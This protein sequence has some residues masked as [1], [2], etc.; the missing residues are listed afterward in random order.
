MRG[1]TD[2][3]ESIP[4]DLYPVFAQ[5]IPQMGRLRAV[6]LLFQHIRLLSVVLQV[7]CVVQVEAHQLPA[8]RQAT[9][10]V[11]QEKVDVDGKFS[12]IPNASTADLCNS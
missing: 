4:F 1:S 10:V 5:S 6:L 11:G 9:H 8:A 2:V 12:N 7:N 3:R